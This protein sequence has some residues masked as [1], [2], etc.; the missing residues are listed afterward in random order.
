M[1]IFLE[2]PHQFPPELRIALSDTEEEE[3]HVLISRFHSDLKS[4]V[5]QCFVLRCTYSATRCR[6]SASRTGL[7]Q[8]T[9]IYGRKKAVMN[10]HS[11]RLN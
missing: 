1:I 11:R 5:Y 6:I 9:S 10:A 2:E 3:H 8:E 4:A 7:S